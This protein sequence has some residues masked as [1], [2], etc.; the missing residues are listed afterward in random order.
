MLRSQQL[1]KD[2]DEDEDEDDDD[3]PNNARNPRP[4]SAKKGHGHK[5]LS[6]LRQAYIFVWRDIMKVAKPA[7]SCSH[8]LFMRADSELAQ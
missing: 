6:I 7:E 8:L 3:Q 2:M 4:R 5:E 1:V